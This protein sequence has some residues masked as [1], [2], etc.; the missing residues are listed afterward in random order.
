MLL[1]QGGMWQCPPG[2]SILP[3]PL[4]GMMRRESRSVGSGYWYNLLMDNAPQLQHPPPSPS[5]VPPRQGQWAITRQMPSLFASLLSPDVRP[6]QTSCLLHRI[7]LIP[8]F[9]Q[10]EAD[11]T[12]PCA[13]LQLHPFW[14]VFPTWL[15]GLLRTAR[16]LGISQ[17]ADDTLKD[18]V[19]WT[20][21]QDLNPHETIHD[22]CVVTCFYT[23]VSHWTRASTAQQG[24]I[25]RMVSK[26]ATSTVPTE[27]W[28]T[29]D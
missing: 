15:R 28:P 20:T 19:C 10:H 4:L 9:L 29:P 16:V 5:Q 24:M 12:P 14:Q 18:T 22:M 3:L 7:F 21:G 25:N 2:T 23:V 11:S 17:D 1:C 8:E 26:T 6:A 13:V 27:P